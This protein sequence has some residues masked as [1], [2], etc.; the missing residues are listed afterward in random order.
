MS[1]EGKPTCWVPAYTGAVPVLS[2]QWGEQMW[3]DRLGRL[4]LMAAG[5]PG[6]DPWL[7]WGPGQHC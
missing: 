5:W 2:P 1:E 7:V 6:E 4:G 3:P